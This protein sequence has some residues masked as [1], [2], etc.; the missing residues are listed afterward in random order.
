[1]SNCTIN[2]NIEITTT[3]NNNQQSEPVMLPPPTTTSQPPIDVF[4]ERLWSEK[5]RR[6]YE[7][8]DKSAMKAVRVDGKV[9]DFKG[10]YMLNISAEIG[11]RNTFMASSE[12]PGSLERFASE[13]MF[14]KLKFTMQE[15]IFI[16][17]HLC[18][19]VDYD[20]VVYCQL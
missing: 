16:H 4:K 2:E 6:L 7:L 5:S 8:I 18:V 19:I 12:L 14:S 15:V 13:W 3:N 20:C 1:L 9:Y 10:I 11:V 17:I